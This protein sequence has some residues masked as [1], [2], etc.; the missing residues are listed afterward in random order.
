MSTLLDTFLN[1]LGVIFGLFVCGGSVFL[2][3]NELVWDRQAKSGK[4]IVILIAAF[5]FGASIIFGIVS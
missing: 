4:F 5:L 2:L 3:L 1:I